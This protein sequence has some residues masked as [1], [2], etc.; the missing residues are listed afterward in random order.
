MIL[1]L[2]EWPWPKVLGRET[3]SETHKQMNAVLKEDPAYVTQA[4]TADVL[5]VAFFIEF[6]LNEMAW[7]TNL[8]L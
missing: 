4:L 1:N 5:L 3:G 6:I 8:L 2:K 7:V